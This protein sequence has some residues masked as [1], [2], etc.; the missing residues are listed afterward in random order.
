MNNTLEGDIHKIIC[1]TNSIISQLQDKIKSLPQNHRINEIN[2]KCFTM[3]YS[4]LGSN[5]NIS[6]QYHDF[7][8]QYVYLCD[9]IGR[10]DLSNLISTLTKIIRTGKHTRSNGKHY[11]STNTKVFHNDVILSLCKITNIKSNEQIKEEKE[12][13]HL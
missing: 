11:Y 1:D 12:V 9:V 6:P 10:C 4:D 3:K 2:D 5:K 13:I 8:N 7:K